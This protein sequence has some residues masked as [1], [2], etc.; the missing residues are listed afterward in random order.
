MSIQCH[1]PITVEKVLDDP[2]RI[3]RLI[4][5]NSPYWPVQRYFRSDS[6]NQSA[7]GEKASERPPFTA[8]VFRGDWYYDRPLI[9]GIQEIIDHPGFIEAAKQIFNA[10]RVRPFSV[11]ANLTW[12]LPFDQG[13]GHVDVPEF[14]GI[15]RTDY[16]VWTLALMGHSGLF[17]AERIEIV[18]TVA[19][20]YRGSDGGLMYW[21]DGPNARPSIHEGAIYNTAIVGDNDRM[22]HRVRPVG[23]RDKGI[24]SGLT[25]DSLLVHRGDGDWEIVEGDPKSGE[26]RAIMRWED[27]RISLSWKARVFRDAADEARVAEHSDDIKIDEVFAR[28]YED[29]DKRGVAFDQPAQ[30]L[31][32]SVFID[33]LTKTYF[34]EPTLHEPAH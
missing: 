32:D 31:K 11:Y 5:D 26:S 8:P 1:P 29:L 7:S 13:G 14:R 10:E 24:V 19:W 20:F 34:S 2:E 9:D 27:L 23:S 17:E 22:F 16:P 25:L 33:L 3:R 4:E 18:T 28:F 15:S 21:P 12:Q 6:E 30:P